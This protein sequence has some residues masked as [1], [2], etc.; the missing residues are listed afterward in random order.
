MTRLTL[1]AIVLITIG[2]SEIESPLAVD[3]AQAPSAPRM[4]GEYAIPEGIHPNLAAHFADFQPDMTERE[5][6]FLLKQVH[7][8]CYGW[9]L[10]FHWRVNR[11]LSER[12]AQRVFDPDDVVIFN[13]L[14][15]DE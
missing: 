14:Y 12:A 10:P 6:Q 3:V 2:C 4:P 15:I 5:Y 7:D 11:R 1:L 9:T 13:Q 8:Y